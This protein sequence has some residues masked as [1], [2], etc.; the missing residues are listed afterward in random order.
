MIPNEQESLQILRDALDTAPS[1][2]ESFLSARCQGNEAL[3]ERI[4]A[5]LARIALADVHGVDDD[6]GSTLD[7]LGESAS[8]P[9]QNPEDALIGSLLGPFRVAERIGRGGMG[10]VYR[11]VREG[12]DFKQEVAIKLIRRGYD[13]DDVHARFLRERR[14]LARL[15]H[16]NLARF[17]D[18]GVAAEGRPWFALEF[19]RGESITRWC[20]AQRLSVR[21]RVKLFLDVCAAVQYAH[22]RLVVHRDLKPG[23]VLVDETGAVRLLDFGVAG[24]LASDADSENVPSTIGARHG[25]T[26]EYAAPEQFAGGAVGI[27][28]DVYSLGVL[29]YE[30]V[31]G[32]LPYALDRTDPGAAARTV[33]E[34]E[35]Q[36]LAGAILRTVGEQSS[37]PDSRLASRATGLR[38]YRRLV[39]GDLARIVEKALA[40]EPER[41]YE[42]V[43]AFADDLTR[44]LDGAPVRAT[45]NRFGY[46]L[47]R[48]VKRNRLAVGLAGLSALAV[49]AGVVGMAWQI[50]E[51]R[52][53]RDAAETEAERSRGV[54]DYIMLMFGEAGEGS[55]TDKDVVRG[56]LK[57]NAD[58]VFET[59]KDQ[60]SAGRNIALML[61]ELYLHLG[62][63]ESARS[64]LE[65]LLLWPGI[66]ADPNVLASAR[67]NLA[68]VEN[69]AGD[70]VRARVL[71]DQAQSFWIA[72]DSRNLLDLN[73]SRGTQAKIELA[74]GH[75]DAAIATLE[76]SNAERRR[77]LSK[78]DRELAAGVSDLSFVLLS[79]GRVEETFARADECI[80]LYSSLGLARSSAGLA[81]VNNRAN[82]AYMLGRF[83]IAISGMR[84]GVEL[85]RELFGPTTELAEMMNNLGVMLT[86][87]G[88]AAE[89]I[90]ILQEALI[91]AVD[92]ADEESQTAFA[93]R[94]NLADAYVAAGRIGEAEPLAEKSIVIGR[95]HLGE[96]S[97]FAGAAYASLARVRVA[98]GRKSEAR[99]ALDRAT[100]IFTALGEPGTA[101][102]KKLEPLR[103]ALN[104]S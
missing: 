69:E 44:W 2:R 22:T 95:D 67:Y 37:T 36:P 51:T 47:G 104:G 16:P 46:R 70:S 76:Q 85:R 87:Q 88:K 79:A 20:D 102:L 29:V 92:K 21:Q 3:R 103:A 80:A 91:I 11:G 43:Q 50:R 30:M 86:R 5:M 39:N 77:L 84:E 55:D 96:G 72:Q 28:A 94:R 19:V 15:S 57:R 52:L 82:A 7:T 23:N 65:R 63:Q 26:P 98:Q 4:Q 25:M 75:V 59:Y 45:A 33:A 9:T 61:G 73:V 34:T 14:I 78:P 66:E 40:K 24:L 93:P 6:S 58:R 90:P 54:R 8:A 71:L 99:T 1:E 10:I 13:F 62:E 89:A 81:A 100:E 32:V 41:R 27:A 74:E 83:D 42:T 60:P 101:Q 68:Q 12:T 31:T 97:V 18:G 64:V 38:G 53:Q 17:I 48:F 49:L 56:L 35:P